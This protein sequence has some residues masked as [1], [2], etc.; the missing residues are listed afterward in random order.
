GRL[1][2]AIGAL[3][4]ANL[5]RLFAGDNLTQFQMES[6]AYSVLSCI[7]LVGM[8]LIWFAPETKGRAL[9]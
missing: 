3:Q 5:T 7:Y 1:V 8:V 2:A 9:S 4:L 6:N